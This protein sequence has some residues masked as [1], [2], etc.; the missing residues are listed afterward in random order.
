MTEIAISRVIAH[1]IVKAQ[2]KPIEESNIRN[3]VLDVRDKTVKKLLDEV[4]KVYG[5]R[6]NAAHYGTFKT[7]F[8]R[9]P[10]PDSYSNYIDSRQADSDFISLTR[11]VMAELYRLAEAATASTGGYIL[12][13]DYSIA[14]ERFFLIVMIKKT[15]GIMISAQLEPEE[16]DRL[17]LDRLSQ[18]ARIN[19]TKY[20]AFLK[21]GDEE[22]ASINYLSFISPSAAKGTAGYF[23]SALGC[24]KGSTSSQATKLV[25]TETEKYFRQRADWNVNTARLRRSITEYLREKDGSG[26]SARLADIDDIVRKHIPTEQADNAEAIVEDL[27]KHLNSEDIGIP[28]EFPVHAA[29]LKKSTHLKAKTNYWNLEFDRAALGKTDSAAVYYDSKKKSLTL[30]NIPEDFI[31]EVESHLNNGSL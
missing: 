29:T 21:A 3:T 18:A 26:E 14:A 20:A 13:A 15:P 24:S 7:T 2:H 8:D 9:G 28:V 1:E 19:V 27:I 31:A 25:I 11:V 4:T 16:L 5:S 12:F 10:F 23:I 6:M 30:K 22:K 17:E